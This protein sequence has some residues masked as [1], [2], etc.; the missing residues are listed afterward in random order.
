MTWA[1]PTVQVWNHDATAGLGILRAS[2]AFT[3]S[4]VFCDVGSLQLDMPMDLAGADLLLTDEDRQVRVLQPGA[5]DMWFLLDDDSR[6]D[7]SDAPESEVAKFTLRSLAGVLDEAKVYMDGV[8]TDETPGGIVS[9]LVLAA[10]SRGLCQGITVA[11]NASADA[12][13]EPWPED[14]TVEYGP[15]KSLLE[16][17]KGLSGA[18]VMEWRFN[19]RILELHA[20]G[21]GL[22]RTIVKPLRPGRDVSGA[23]YARS[24]RSVATAVIVEGASRALSRR[25]AGL[26]GRRE[27][28]AF[29]SQSNA[30]NSPTAEKVGDYYLAAHADADVQVTHDVVDAPD[31]LTPWVD[32][33]PGDRIPSLAG[34]QTVVRRRIAQVV[35]TIGSDGDSASL[36]LGTLL[37]VAEERF[38]DQLRRLGVSEAGLA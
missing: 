11:G 34:S 28:E 17:V 22:D 15:G 8:F 18:R 27:R 16:V 5:P 1:A 20:P 2:S 21:E 26:A 36:E 38:D 3:V 29:I 7:I 13:G 14:F 10:Q 33:R 35:R 19:G 6:E 23:P 25:H 12:S 31:G 9:T 30:L 37:Q 24:R 4:D 32:Y